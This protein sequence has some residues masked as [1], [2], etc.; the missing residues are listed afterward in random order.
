[1]S[2][3]A[4]YYLNKFN[5]TTTKLVP[6]SFIS[7]GA[8]FNKNPCGGGGNILPPNISVSVTVDTSSIIDYLSVITSS[9]LGCPCGGSTDT[10]SI[11]QYLSII[12]SSIVYDNY[13]AVLSSI[14][15]K[16]DHLSTGSGGAGNQNV[17][18]EVVVNVDLNA[19]KCLLSSI[20]SKLDYL[21]SI[22][23]KLDYLSSGIKVNQDVTQTANIDVDLSGLN[24]YLSSL[25][26]S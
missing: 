5:A 10:S 6:T 14:D 3:R 12:T 26:C 19:Q 1:M 11:N 8:I 9:I 4:N 15:G 17:K 24:K 21:S 25:I 22:D 7:S 18:Q 23:S 20:N 13:H 16:L 2:C